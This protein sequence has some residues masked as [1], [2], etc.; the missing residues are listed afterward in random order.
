[1][2]YFGIQTKPVYLLFDSQITSCSDHDIRLR[3]LLDRCFCRPTSRTF[4][5]LTE[6]RQYIARHFN[7]TF[8][9]DFYTS[10]SCKISC[11]LKANCCFL[12]TLPPTSDGTMRVNQNIDWVKVKA[13]YMEGDFEYLSCHLFQ[14]NAEV[15][16]DEACARRQL[17]KLDTRPHCPFNSASCPHDESC[18]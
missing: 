10:T 18:E 11:F 16:D 5:L 2:C 12:S 3:V 9:I 15:R 4:F 6:K 17:T 13:A 7:E 8:V 1:M 14:T